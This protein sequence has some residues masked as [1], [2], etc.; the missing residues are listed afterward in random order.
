MHHIKL[1]SRLA[2]WNIKRMLIKKKIKNIEQWF[3]KKM[4][5]F[6]GPKL[7]FKWDLE[8]IIQHRLFI[9]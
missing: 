1:K 9:V 6:C 7:K 5:N 3:N 4:N 2:H 8:K